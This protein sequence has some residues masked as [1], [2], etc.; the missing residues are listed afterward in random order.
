MTETLLRISIPSTVTYDWLPH[1][2]GVYRA[3]LTKPEDGYGS[4][5]SLWDDD[6]LNELQ[7]VIGSVKVDQ[8]SYVQKSSLSDCEGDDKSFFW[9]GGTQTL[10][11]HF[12][13]DDIPEI[14]SISIGIQGGY[15]FIGTEESIYIDDI[16]YQ[17]RIISVPNIKKKVD[18][19][20]VGKMTF[21]DQKISLRNGDGALDDFIQNPIPG[22]EASIVLFDTETTTELEYY[23]GFITADSSTIDALTM[24]MTD[25]RRSENIKV[26]R[27]R[28]DSTTYPDIES[29]YVGK[30]IP[31]GYGAN[32]GIKCFPLNGEATT[33]TN[34]DFKY[35]TDATVLTEVRVKDDDVWSTVAT[36]SSTPGSGIFSVLYA[37]ATNTS[38]AVLECVCDATLRAEVTPGDVI[39]DMNDRYNSITYDS[40]NYDT[41]E[42]TSEDA[43]LDDVALYMNK[44]KE[45]FKWIETIQN[46]SN[47]FFVYDIQGDGKR[48]LRVNDPNRTSARTIN[49]TDIKNDLKPVERDF[50][51]FSSTVA[52][53]YSHDWQFD[54]DERI[55]VDTYE[56]DV[57]EKYGVASDSEFESLLTTSANATEKAAVIAEDQQEARAVITAVLHEDSLSNLDLKLYD[58][59]SID[60]SVPGTGYY[61]HTV[62]ADTMLADH[63]GSDT[64]TADHT[65]SDTMTTEI[66][67]ASWVTTEADRD[68]WGTIRGQVIGIGYNPTDLSYTLTIRERPESEVI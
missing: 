5:Y 66:T 9:N 28:F 11:I 40:S 13:F 10:Y 52:V 6:G 18:A 26:P 48:T 37:N 7:L 29:K 31:E 51:E 55:D 17:P 59:V 24:K 22:A 23:T 63:T 61:E 67:T 58:V 49:S 34:I 1:E 12:E 44:E 56:D 65:G 57:V 2:Q 19:F 50:T 8:E 33:P 45:F 15:S 43:K 54:T 64:M 30:I 42:W 14:T 46:G 38:G 21:Q 53:L 4:Y 60:F 41:T 16:E 36:V 3:T 35:A 32:I 27:T 47:L 39:A 20:Q 25:K 62:P 68:Y